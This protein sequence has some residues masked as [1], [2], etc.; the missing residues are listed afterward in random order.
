MNL[1]AAGVRRLCSIS[2]FGFQ[3]SDL[4]F[5]PPYVGCDGSEIQGARLL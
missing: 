5:E 2:D 1:V 3:I 4:K